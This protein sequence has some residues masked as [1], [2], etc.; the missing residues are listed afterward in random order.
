MAS[1]EQLN[2][3]QFFKDTI[4]TLSHS[5]GFYGRLK[6]NLDNAE[7]E[8]LDQLAQELPNFKDVVDVIFFC[9]Q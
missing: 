1:I 7:V 8:Q 6:H 5:Q 4:N 2:N 3:L 9:E